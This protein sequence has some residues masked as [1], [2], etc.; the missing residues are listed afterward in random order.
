MTDMKRIVAAMT[1]AAVMILSSLAVA[2]A[3]PPE[4]AAVEEPAGVEEAAAEPTGT[5]YV[6]SRQVDVDHPLPMEK[7]TAG[8]R[9]GRFTIQD[10]A[11][12]F[13]LR[14][15]LQ[16][17]MRGVS[18]WQEHEDID[19]GVELRRMRLGFDG[20]MF[21]PD[22][23]YQFIFTNRRVGGAVSV[24]DAFVTYRFAEGLHLRAG[25]FKDP[26]A[27][28]H[29]VSSQ[30][31]LAAELSLQNALISGG[32]SSYV[33]GLS[34]IYDPEGR[35]RT[36]VAVHQGY[37]TLNTGW[38]AGGG[39][40]FI[41][42]QD[43]DIGFSG[44]VEHMVRGQNWRQYADMTAMRNTGPLLVLGGGAGWTLAGSEQVLFHT[45]D[46]VWKT[47][48]GLAVF[49]AINGVYTDLDDANLYDWG[50]LGQAAQMLNEKWELF[51]RYG[52]TRLDSDRG[53]PERNVHEVTVG[54]N[55]YLRGHNAKLT[56]DGTWLPKG[57]PVA[58]PGIGVR[59]GDGQQFLVRAQFQL[60]F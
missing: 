7:F 19:S 27:H 9:A 24:L 60:L 29:R 16:L 43:T 5:G 11:G 18:N 1:L 6:P 33:Q 50:L 59:E 41:G 45:I 30:R 2:N 26:V 49:G 55:Y 20:N 52:Y 39:T 31:M 14:P 17:Q 15:M 36:E 13:V 8:Y 51:G 44:R 4:P 25:Q 22:L 35:W 58:E 12:D 38:E 53:L 47:D 10:D 32:Q 37:N 3:P 40:A 21:G 23:R 57:S 42:V 56:L 46:A 48:G 54:T 28:E 34:L